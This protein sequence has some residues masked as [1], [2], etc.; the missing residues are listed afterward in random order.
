MLTIG[1][2]VD[3]ITVTMDGCGR[4]ARPGYV[5]NGGSPE[6]LQCR[7]GVSRP[8]QPF[9]ILNSSVHSVFLGEEQEMNSGSRTT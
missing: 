3:D 7:L 6:K 4:R 1:A 9:T 2:G 8:W 5:R